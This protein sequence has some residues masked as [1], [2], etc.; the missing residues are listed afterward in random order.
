MGGGW[1]RIRP[2]PI[3]RVFVAILVVIATL[4]TFVRWFVVGYD[5]GDDYAK[6]F[7]NEQVIVVIGGTSLEYLRSR[8]KV[9]Q[10]HSPQHVIL[11]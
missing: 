7:S 3:R 2:E 9:T 8:V 11:G 5:H 4:R 10:T 6:L 1:L